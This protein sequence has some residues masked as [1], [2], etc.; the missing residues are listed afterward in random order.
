MCVCVKLRVYVDGCPRST[1]ARATDCEDLR[2]YV[3]VDLLAAKATTNF[4]RERRGNNGRTLYTVVLFLGQIESEKCRH[5]RGTSCKRQIRLVIRSV[6]RNGMIFPSKTVEIR[7]APNR[8]FRVPTIV[9]LSSI[10]V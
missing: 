10:N 1:N 5:A 9:I 2:T 3:L 4:P 7:K 6:A 8:I